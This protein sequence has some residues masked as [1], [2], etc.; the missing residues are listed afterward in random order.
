MQYAGT[1]YAGWQKQPDQPTIQ[2]VLQDR[3]EQILRHP[4]RLVAASRTDAGVHARGQV[5]SLLTHSELPVLRLRRSLNSLLPPE[6]R[7]TAVE[8]APAEFHAL[9]CARLREYRYEIVNGEVLS[10][11]RHGFALQVRVP[12]D[13]DRMEEAA[14][15]ILGEHDFTGFADADRGPARTWRHIEISEWITR[16]ELLCYRVVA[17]GFVKGMVRSLVGTLIE[18]GRGRWEPKWMQHVLTERKRCLAGPSVP[19]CGL[20][21]Q[22]VEYA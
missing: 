11:F 9:R 21:L 6:I 18:I 12:L 17:D 14:R 2:G 13:R 19:A 1:H 20:Y 7:V 8:E 4:A 10:P 22:R 16:E 15:A 5:A 3:L